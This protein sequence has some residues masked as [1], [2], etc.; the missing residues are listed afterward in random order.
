MVEYPLTLI[1][2]PS[3][4]GSNSHSL[5]PTCDFA[6]SYSSPP[7]VEHKILYHQLHSVYPITRQFV[8][9]VGLI[10]DIH[11]L[12][13]VSRKSK[14]TPTGVVVSLVEEAALATF[15]GL[16]EAIEDGEEPLVFRQCEHDTLV[17]L[18][19]NSSIGGERE[20]S[21]GGG[22]EEKPMDSELKP[23][24]SEREE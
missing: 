10:P 14:A 3:G 17:I 24:D 22:G 2:Q 21:R 16:A 12:T 8:K 1:H 19:S 23:S 5:S 20:G 4:Q 7:S 18:G 13:Y 15:Q 6:V 9:A 11:H